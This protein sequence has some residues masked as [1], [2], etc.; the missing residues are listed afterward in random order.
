MTVGQP[1]RLD[2][3]QFVNDNTASRPLLDEEVEIEVKACGLNFLDIM[4]AMGQ[5]QR[6][7][8]GHEAAGVVRRIGSRVTRVSPGDRVVYI[9]QGAMRTNIRSHESA[10]HKLPDSISLEEGVS[11]PV[12]YATAYQSLVEIARLQKGE[13]V[14]IHAAAGGLGQALIQIAKMLEAN[15]YCTVGT[16]AKKQVMLALGIRPDHIFS[17]R[18]LSFAK[19]IKRVTDGR[20]VDVVVNSLAGEALRQSWGCLAPYGRF[21]E[22]GK[23]DILGNSGLDMQPFL[24]NVIFA[25]VNLEAMMVKE[26]LRCSKL[27]SKVLD[28]FEQGA[29]DL[30]R[31][32]SVHDFSDAESV[33]REMQ[34]GSHI[35]NPSTSQVRRDLSASRRLRG[36]GRAQALF[37]AENGARNLAFISR[38]GGARDEA[39][40]LI[41]K[42]EASGV[43]VKTYASDVADKARLKEVIEDISQ[44]MPPIRGVIQG[45]MVLADSLFH[46]MSYD[47][48]VTATRP[49]VQGSWNLHELLPV[50]M[51]FFI[52][53]SSLAGI[54]GS[55]SQGNYAAGNTFQD[56]LVHYRQHKGLPAQSLD[57]GIMKSIGYV[58]EH[59]DVGARLS[60]FKL[61]SVE[62]RHFMHLLRCALAGTAN[63]DTSMA[64]QLLVG[65]GSG[66]IEQATRKTEPNADFYWLRM[67]AQFAHLRQTD[68]KNTDAVDDDDGQHGG[69]SKMIDQLKL[70]KVLGRG[71]RGCAE[72]SAS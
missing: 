67:L 11:I 8:L 69:E 23:K 12:V 63:G 51:D 57:L 9:G 24:D 47:Q 26:P 21:I 49:K 20:G 15:I 72:C 39:K 33:F 70:C 2:T 40:N 16:E 18:D 54:I 4:I 17:S 5:I 37:M 68:I 6:P 46:R 50:D 34:R 44:S 59:G 25:G 27:V 7:G 13:S 52:V 14:L 35:G 71:Q 22:V 61:A 38:S 55:V 43:T 1:G 45:A 60:Q 64:P 65:A 3:L 58:E 53:L 42:L 10:I 62:K 31:P 30:I 19:G 28:L 48:W 41:A 66:G 32:I 56:A 29:I 36:L